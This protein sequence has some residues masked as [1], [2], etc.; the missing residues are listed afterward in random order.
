MKKQ[1]TLCI[2]CAEGRVLLGMKKRGFGA[3][4]WNGYGGKVED[5]ESLEEAAVREMKE[6]VGLVPTEMNKVGILNFS[7]KSEDP[8]LQVHIYKVDA[9]KGEPVETEEMY[10]E[11][12]E[13]EEIPY[14]NMWSDDRQWLPFLLTR[15]LFRGR[16]VFD[17]PATAEHDA[18]IL[19][20]EMDVVEELVS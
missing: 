17:S 12:F 9:F 4:R 2:V 3:G 10:S 15:K 20:S 16:F 18:E 13:Y 1:L 6:E 14:D 5:G 19:E 7:F 11:W 8:D